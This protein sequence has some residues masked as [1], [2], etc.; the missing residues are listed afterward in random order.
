M[1]HEFKKI[2]AACKEASEKNLKTVLASVVDL[3]GSSY[4]RPGVRMLIREDMKMIGAVS[5]GCVEKEILHQSQSVFNNGNAKVIVYDGRYRLGCEGILYILI[6]PMNPEEAFYQNFNEILSSRKNFK[7]TSHFSK[8]DMEVS[9]GTLITFDNLKFTLD[10]SKS[11]PFFE[12]ETLYQSFEQEMKP[13]FSLL[14]IGAEHDAVQLCKQA[15]LTGW[16]VNIITPPDDPKTLADFPGA[17]NLQSIT[18]EE[19]ASIDIDKQT[20]VVVMTHSF[21]KDLKYLSA[22]RKKQLIYL[23]LLGPAKRRERLLSELLEY[24]DDTPD[25]FFEVLHGPSGINIGAETP[26]EIAISVIA[27]ILSVT[28]NQQPFSLKEKKGTIHS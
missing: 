25:S 1:T 23:G 13:C 16:E 17:H 11:A 26:Q 22:L 20:A 4:R 12:K 27:E 15:A 24:H 18:E 6:E 3:E 2:V 8:D 10:K 21:V 9:G 28:R 19:L 14:I 7:L 5:G